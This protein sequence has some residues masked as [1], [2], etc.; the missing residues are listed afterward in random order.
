MKLFVVGKKLFTHV[1]AWEMIG[2]YSTE[3]LALRA[4]EGHSDYFIG[5]MDMDVTSPDEACDWPGAYIPSQRGK[6][7]P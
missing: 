7:N 4:C 3:T 6:V 1:Q 2:V 5:P